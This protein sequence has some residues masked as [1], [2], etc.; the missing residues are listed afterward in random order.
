MSNTAPDEKPKKSI[1]K[2]VITPKRKYFV[3]SHGEI[4]AKDMKDVEIKLKKLQSKQE[5]GDAK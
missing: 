2:R 3:P 4:E 1:A 5:V